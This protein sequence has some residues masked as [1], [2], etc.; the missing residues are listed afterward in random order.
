MKRFFLLFFVLATVLAFL[1]VAGGASAAIDNAELYAA[2][3]TGSGSTAEDNSSNSNDGTISGTPNW[4]TGK[5]GSNALDLDGI[6]EDI[7]FGNTNLPTGDS[8]FSMGFWF[9]TDVD[10]RD[11]ILSYGTDSANQRVGIIL[12]DSA[13]PVGVRFFS[14]S[15]TNLDYSFDYTDN[16]WYHVVG[17]YNSSATSNNWRL[18]ING[19]NVATT[20][21]NGINVVINDVTLGSRSQTSSNYYDGSVD[22]VFIYDRALSDDEISELYDSGNGLNPYSSNPSSNFSVSAVDEYTSSSLSNFSALINGS[23]YNTTNG[24]INTDIPSNSSSLYEITVSSTDSGGYFNRTYTDYNVSSDLEAQLIQ[25]TATFG[26]N[27]DVREKV[28]NEFLG[29]NAV[30]STTNNGGS[31]NV[32]VFYSGAVFPETM[33]LTAGSYRFNVTSAGYYPATSESVNISALQEYTAPAGFVEMYNHVANFTVNVGVG[34]ADPNNFSIDI[35]SDDYN[36]K[37]TLSTTEGWIAANLTHGNYTVTLNDSQFALENYT[38]SLNSS[39]NYTDVTLQAKTA[40]TFDLRFRN[41]TSNA[42][43]SNENITVKFISD[44]NSFNLT[45]SNGTLLLDLLTPDAYEIQ[46]RPASTEETF[47][48]Y[49]VTLSPQSYQNIT[50]YLI[51]ED[52]SD[53]YVA[54][55]L[56]DS[57]SACQA[58]TVSL[59]RYYIAEEQ[60]SVVQMARTDS[61]GQAVL[62]VRPNTVDYKLLFSG[63]CGSFESSPTKLIDSINTYTVFDS[64]NYLEGTQA[65]AG[66]DTG[67]TYVNSTRTFSYSWTSSDNV[68]TAGC[69]EVTKRKSGVRS[70]ESEQCASGMSGSLVYTIPANATN[71]TN[72]YARGYLETSTS[73]STITTNTEE[74]SFLE[75]FFD[76]GAYAPFAALII[77][78][79]MALLFGTSAASLVVGT[80]LTLLV[81]TQFYFINLGWGT[82]STVIV[83]AGVILYRLRTA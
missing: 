81:M 72:W 26:F 73:F 43:L 74:V 23:V 45:T 55:V 70:I 6:S 54:R 79:A 68:I 38:V 44:S 71:Q 42:L 62:R 52:I 82:L 83:L 56:D 21:E 7:N 18:Y 29:Q 12:R 50:L 77:F 9:K 78:I 41:E 53:F 30:I 58:Q 10:Q 60:Y 8:S 67:L 76:Q 63:P 4:I 35:Y 14:F 69:L 40:R 51:D 46:Y 37:E 24:T 27:K 17:V 11:W 19:T 61:Q 66:A 75:A 28:S 22:E 48:S 33:N 32:T 49:F 59:L 3:D 80:T 16:Q 25:S 2:L 64:Q 65:V 1:L 57:G 34:T 5:V 47:R 20:T 13:D 36:F 39:Q 31:A 15:S